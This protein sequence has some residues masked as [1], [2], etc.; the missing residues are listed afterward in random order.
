MGFLFDPRLGLGDPLAARSVH[1]E[2][3]TIQADIGRGRYWALVDILV[4]PRL[5][6]ALQSAT[7]NIIDP[8]PGGEI[9]D[10][11][12][13]KTTR[14]FWCFDKT[15]KVIYSVFDADAYEKGYSSFC[16]GEISKGEH[17]FTHNEVTHKNDLC[18]CCYTPIK[19]ALRFLTCNDDLFGEILAN[20]AVLNRRIE[21]RCCKCK[22][23]TAYK[24]LR[25]ECPCMY[26]EKP[27]G[28]GGAK[29]E[30]KM[31]RYNLPAGSEVIY[32]GHGG[33]GGQKEYANK[34]LKKGQKY[35]LSGSRIGSAMT[36]FF[37]EGIK[38]GFNS[39][40]FSVEDKGGVK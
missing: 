1:L 22:K 24:V 6:A 20:I 31:A 5:P 4:T 36:Y 7:G 30:L 34:T 29:K 16:F 39:V 12:N 14:P 27:Q 40:L 19:G 15:A 32:T 21:S 8:T 33:Y 3:D 9:M 26:K 37:L 25:H 38:D 2:T 18:H 13:P 11:M 28:E 23:P 35:I 10:E 17:Q